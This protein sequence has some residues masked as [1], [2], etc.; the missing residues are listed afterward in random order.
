MCRSMTWVLLCSTTVNMAGPVLTTCCAFHCM[1]LSTRYHML[2]LSDALSWEWCCIPEKLFS[3]AVKWH[4]A[5][6]DKFWDMWNYH[7][8]K[9]F[10]SWLSVRQNGRESTTEFRLTDI[11]HTQTADPLWAR[12]QAAC[13]VSCTNPILAQVTLKPPNTFTVLLMWILKS[14]FHCPL[15]SLQTVVSGS[16]V[17]HF[18]QPVLEVKV[19]GL[20][21]WCSAAYMRTREQQCCRILEVAADFHEIMVLQCGMQPSIA[22]DS[23][24]W[25][26]STARHTYH[27]PNQLH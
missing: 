10:Q 12:L 11:L 4:F 16:F 20:D 14:T 1:S 5:Y 21:T 19:K 13:S 26:R 9:T 15:V 17:L 23:R 8:C 2:L 3:G 24:Q 18:F 22:H 6:V 25:T 27:R 7:E